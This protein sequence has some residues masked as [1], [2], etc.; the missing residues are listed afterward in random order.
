MRG[1]I[2]YMKKPYL[3]NLRLDEK[4]KMLDLFFIQLNPWQFSR[5]AY[6]QLN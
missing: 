2:R 3:S 5:V 1:N 4:L 6:L